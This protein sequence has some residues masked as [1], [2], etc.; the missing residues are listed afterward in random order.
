[1]ANKVLKGVPSQWERQVGMVWSLE[2]GRLLR[3]AAASEAPDSGH[4]EAGKVRSIDTD[5]S[6]LG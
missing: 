2:L 5:C 4:T 3:L 1:M 6:K